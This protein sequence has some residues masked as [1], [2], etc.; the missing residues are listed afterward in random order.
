MGHSLQR[1]FGGSFG[2]FDP[3]TEFLQNINLRVPSGLVASRK[4]VVDAIKGSKKEGRYILLLTKNNVALDLALNLLESKKPLVI[5]GSSFPS[6][7]E[8]TAIWYEDDIS[9]SSLTWYAC[10]M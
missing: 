4:L 3:T 1:N 5:F 10:M 9:F 2:T 6:D 8:Y 7:Q